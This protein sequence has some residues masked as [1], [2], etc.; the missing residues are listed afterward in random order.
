MPL[1][2]RRQT[3]VTW[4]YIAWNARCVTWHPSGQT[5]LDRHHFGRSSS[6]DC[7]V[8]RGRKGGRA[9]WSD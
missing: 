2:L 3:L 6:S 8:F 5:S 7:W 4:V 9:R 1:L